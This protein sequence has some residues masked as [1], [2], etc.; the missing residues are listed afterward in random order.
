MP[1]ASKR[2]S[3]GVLELTLEGTLNEQLGNQLHRAIRDENA[4]RVLVDLRGVEGYEILGREQL[5]QAHA[6]LVERSSRV[7]YIADRARIRGMVLLC[8]REASDEDGRPV[9]TR[10][11]AMRWLESSETYEA[12]TRRGFARWLGKGRS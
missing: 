7:A 3:D 9:L 8:M 2:L 12:A 1:C 4:K 10:E 5:G 11:Q 6:L